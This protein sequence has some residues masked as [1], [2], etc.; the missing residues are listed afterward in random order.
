MFTAYIDDAGT[1]PDQRVAIATALVLPAHRIQAFHSEWNTFSEKWGIKDFHASACAVANPKSDFAGWDEDKVKAAFKRVRQIIKKYGLRSYSLAV[2][3]VDYEEIVPVEQRHIFGNYHYTY[4]MQNLVSLLDQ[5]AAPNGVEHP[6]E[7]IFD[8]IDP[9]TQKPERV[10]IENALARSEEARPGR[11]AG[12]Y[13]FRKRKEWPGLQCV[14]L[15]GWTCYR[16]ALNTFE[17]TPLSA[18]QAD[19]L[20]DFD[21]YRDGRW[22]TAIGQTRQQIQDSVIELEKRDWENPLQVHA[23]IKHSLV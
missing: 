8:W 20:Q 18:L 11:F 15:V 9:R 13:S 2:N 14:D 7:F 4:A 10:E 6:L 21:S 16:F 22:L 23:Y 12:H 19:C 17:K 1:A 3:K 5:W